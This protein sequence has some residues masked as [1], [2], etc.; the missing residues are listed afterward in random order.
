MVLDFIFDEPQSMPSS[1]LALLFLGVYPVARRLTSQC[2]HVVPLI[3]VLGL[4]WK[5]EQ[6]WL[7]LCYLQC[8]FSSI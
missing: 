5:L 7:T 4:P 6:Q 8:K 3:S 2:C 1:L